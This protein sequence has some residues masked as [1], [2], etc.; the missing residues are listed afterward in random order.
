L[1]A[2]TAT[3]FPRANGIPLGLI[4]PVDG[5]IDASGQYHSFYQLVQPLKLGE[6]WAL[7]ADLVDA[8]TESPPEDREWVP[9]AREGVERLNEKVCCDLRRYLL[10]FSSRTPLER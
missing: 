1:A 6:F 7:L 10:S 4:A 9:L 8:A 3:S 2:G 5:R